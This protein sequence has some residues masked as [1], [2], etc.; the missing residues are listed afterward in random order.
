MSEAVERLRERLNTLSDKHRVIIEET[1]E[2]RVEIFT[3]KRI[4]E[5]ARRRYQEYERRYALEEVRDIRVVPDMES[6]R[7]RMKEINEDRGI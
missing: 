5:D 4:A 2:L 3:V 7:K 1:N 6:E